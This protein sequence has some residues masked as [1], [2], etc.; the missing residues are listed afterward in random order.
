MHYVYY[1]FKIDE[2]NKAYIGMT[3]KPIESGYKGS[4]TCIKRAFKKYGKE[5][6]ARINLGEFNNK[7][8]CHYWEGFYIKTYKTGF[9]YGG[10]NVHPKGG[11]SCRDEASDD[12]RTKISK[13][14]TGKKLSEQC[15]INIGKA[16]KGRKGPNLGKFGVN[17]PRYGKKHSVETKQKIGETNKNI[18]EE[19]RKKM[20]LAK[21]G[22]PSWNKGLKINNYKNVTSK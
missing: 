21:I 13:A 7:D 15:K 22:K 14:L 4:G 5:N 10:Y 19:T 9:E 6:F 2:P 8:E 20:S 16:G 11:Y 18:S 12:T 17:S 1:T 3:I